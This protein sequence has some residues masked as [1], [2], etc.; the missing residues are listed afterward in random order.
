ML[1][2]IYIPCPCTEL[3]VGYGEY[4]GYKSPPGDACLAEGCRYM[5]S[6]PCMPIISKLLVSWEREGASCCC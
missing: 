4:P 1:F 5:C 2:C 3:G 6:S